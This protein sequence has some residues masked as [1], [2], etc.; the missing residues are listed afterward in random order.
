MQKLSCLSSWD[1]TISILSKRT[2]A[3]EKTSC[4]GAEVACNKIYYSAVNVP[5]TSKESSNFL[6][7]RSKF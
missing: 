5:L 7:L 6:S 1:V 3:N 2:Q 4:L